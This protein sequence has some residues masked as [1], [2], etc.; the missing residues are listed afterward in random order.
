M[1]SAE[2]VYHQGKY[3]IQS[4]QGMQ[5]YVYAGEREA[6]NRLGVKREER[7]DR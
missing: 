4:A 7:A 1:H 3:R 6:G 2:V 5:E